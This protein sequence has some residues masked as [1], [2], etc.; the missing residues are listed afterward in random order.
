LHKQL[1]DKL[2]KL[3]AMGYGKLKALPSSQSEEILLDGKKI[4]LTTWID[5]TDPETLR[6]VL[7]SYRRSFVPGVGFISAKGALLSKDGT[8]SNLSEKQL[9]D[10]T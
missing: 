5:E 4:T 1:D 3:L 6:I 10:F 8:C 9:Y 2:S 7:Q